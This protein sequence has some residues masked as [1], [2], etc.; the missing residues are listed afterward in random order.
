[1]IAGSLFTTDYLKRGVRE[2]TAFA[3]LQPGIAALKLQVRALLEAVRNKDG[4]VEGQTEERIVKPLLDLL[5]WG[6]CW[7]VQERLGREDVPD[8]LLYPDPETFARADG[9][10]PGVR[11]RNAVA[12]ADA[13][14]WRVD[15]DK[16]GSGVG[17]DEAPSGQILRYL[18]RA[19]TLSNGRVLWGVLTNGRVWRLY[20][21]AAQDRLRD[22]FEVDL[23]AAL[24]PPAQTAL[25]LGDRWTDGE[26]AFALWVHFFRRTAFGVQAEGGRSLHREALDEGRRWQA[27]LQASL[28]GWCSEASIP[29]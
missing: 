23:Q 8:Y 7:S 10:A 15:L 26:Q 18:R 27:R 14:A 29:G 19:D 28:S 6:G 22:Y 11:Y 4:L 2:T 13:K 12:L 1:M 21:Q 3:E 24:N 9:E 17:P 16:R 5:G 20:F 25:D